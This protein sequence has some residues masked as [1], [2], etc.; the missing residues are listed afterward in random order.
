MAIK[1]DSVE[2]YRDWLNKQK[3]DKQAE[4]A[5]KPAPRPKKNTTKEK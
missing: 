3:V 4:P 2:E 1:F 5:K